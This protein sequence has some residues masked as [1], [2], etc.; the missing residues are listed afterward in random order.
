MRVFIATKLFQRSHRLIWAV[1]LAHLR[2][3]MRRLL[4]CTFRE[5]MCHPMAANM[6]LVVHRY[7]VGLEV[8]L[9]LL[10]EVRA[11]VCHRRPLVKS[12]EE[13]MMWAGRW[14]L[15]RKW[16]K[17]VRN[18]INMKMSC[19]PNSIVF[20]CI[21][22]AKHAEFIKARG[23]HYSNEAEAMKVSVHRHFVTH[24]SHLCRKQRNYS[25]K[26]T[27]SWKQTATTTR[28][29]KTRTWRMIFRPCHLCHLSRGVSR[30]LTRTVSCDA[31]AGSQMYTYPFPG[32]I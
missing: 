32:L 20:C 9:D 29:A 1:D 26:K 30:N 13:R 14:S 11:S 27:N 3:L 5:M 22:A 10:A 25:H 12:S 7:L 23:R 16:T 2:A 18:R 6:V 8:A 4:I 17:K 21:A 19:M 28:K 24:F 31:I 15:K